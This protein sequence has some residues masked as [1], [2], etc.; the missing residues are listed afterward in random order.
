MQTAEIIT[1]L[2]S[3]G[4]RTR[5]GADKRLGG[6]GPAEGGTLLVN[7]VAATVPMD[8]PYAA[9]SPWEL[10][11]GPSGPALLREGR[12]V[13]AAVEL[14]ASPAFY[15]QT[16]E[17]GVPLK[18]VALLHGRDCLASTVLQRCI[19]WDSP[20]R[21]AFCGIELSLAGGSTL[22]LKTPEQ[23][24][25]AA[26]KAKELD[27]VKHVVLTTGSAAPA[28]REIKHLAACAKA[29]KDASGLPVHAQFLP[30]PFVRDLER[31]A[32]AGVDT[33]GI[34]IENFDPG[35]LS[36]YAMPKYGLGLG[37]FIEAWSESVGIFGP[38]QVSSFVIAGLG[39]DPAG[40]VAGCRLLAEL[41]VYPFLLP[42]RPIPGSEL[43]E[44]APPEP[45]Y[46]TGLYRQ[47]AAILQQTGLGAAQSKAGCVRCGAC[48]ALGS[49][50]LPP[51]KLVVRP[52]RDDSERAAALAVRQRV[53]VKE[54]AIVSGSDADEW[55]D[56]SIHLMALVDGEIL[57]TVRVYQCDDPPT[58]WVGGRLAVDQGQRRTG[59]GAALV[60]EAMR[61]VRRQGC[62]HFS[63]EIQQAN[64][65]FF[66]RLGWAKAGEPYE[67]HGWA[68]QPM[69][70]DLDQAPDLAYGESHG[71]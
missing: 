47:V 38:G 25:L 71:A 55:D 19:F 68:H 7:G 32:Q 5:A 66:E 63:A 35:V 10:E 57:G 12:T 62:T 51:A 31:L 30:P 23:M 37:R 14:V 43:A 42:L 29:I 50:E 6:A 8:S 34:H 4:L 16:T 54:Q 67:I 41:G 15:G 9:G 17:E 70:A 45:E 33:V 21:C 39:E 44:A 36:S 28:G 22:E 24:A 18:Q 48:S 13:E 58:A 26:A 53:F 27:G 65:A 49:W 69:T 46:M 1:H 59:A 2:Q 64:V 60:R 52:A 11:A 3:K 20:N 61:T 40:L 56:R